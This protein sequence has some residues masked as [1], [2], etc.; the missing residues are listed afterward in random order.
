MLSKFDIPA[1]WKKAIIEV[2][3][4]KMIPHPVKIKSE[5]KLTCLTVAGIEDIRSAL[6]EGLAL[7]TKDI[8]VKIRVISAP[9]YEVFTETVKKNEGLKIISEV[10]KIIEQAIKVRSGTFSFVTKPEIVG[11]QVAKDVEEQ[12]KEIN[13]KEGDDEEEEEDHD[14]GIKANIEGIDNMDE[15]KSEE[16]D[17]N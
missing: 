17:D 10:V 5:I 3:N 15:G 14:E 11:E 2:V 7:S 12:L 6:K 9:L 16:G 1:E 8:P 13:M 4:V